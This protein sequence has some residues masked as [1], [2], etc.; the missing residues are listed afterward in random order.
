MKKVA[1][2]ICLSFLLVVLV[3]FIPI[4]C[5][6]WDGFDYEKGDY[7]SID[8][9]NLVRSGNDIEIFDYGSGEYHDVTVESISRYGS[10]VELEVYDNDTGEY[11]TLDMD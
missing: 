4:L 8:K 2:V 5:I 6:S 9:G 11:R 3:L 7:I 1:T 10:G